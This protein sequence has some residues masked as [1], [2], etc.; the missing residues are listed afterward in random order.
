MKNKTLYLILAAIFIHFAAW[1]QPDAQPV[2]SP[3]GRYHDHASLDAMLLRKMDSL[4]VPGLSFAII[5]EGKIAYHAALGVKN[6]ETGQ[7]VTNQ[8][9]FEAASLSKPL[10]AYFAMKMAENGTLDL[11]KPLHQYMPHPAIDSSSIE[12]YRLITG[13]MVLAHSTGFPNWSHGESIKL[14]F[15]PGTGFS[16]SGEAY[17][18]LAAVIG[19]LN[20]VGY[21]SDLNQVF[22]DQVAIPMGLSH[23]SFTWTDHLAA[24]KATGHQAGEPTD[25]GPQGKAFGAGYS[26]HTESAEY[27]RFLIALMKDQGLK[28]P[29]REE[30]LREHTHFADT[31]H[32]KQ[33]IGQTGWA[34]G[35]A[36]KPSDHGMMYM[37]TGNNH[38]FQAYAMIIPE[39]NYGIVLFTNSDKMEPLLMSLATELGPVF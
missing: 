22:L 19:Q 28:P 13:R 37:H 36:M 11:D 3:D 15:R 29:T 10:F 35:F 20:G 2:K 33:E 26:L 25:S 23:T 21:E 6:I 4:G 1:S 34:L 17:Q 14:A 7:P 9:I 24:H 39:E 31:N 18:Y 16:Y 32:L 8:T 38:D 27:A 12:D 30:M 5:N